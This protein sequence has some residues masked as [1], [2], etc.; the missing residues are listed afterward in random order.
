MRFEE[1]QRARGKSMCAVRFRIEL[2]IKRRKE[3]NENAFIYFCRQMHGLFITPNKHAKQ[4]E[5]N[6][7]IKAHTTT[8]TTT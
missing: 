2:L 1:N 8:T 4:I 7:E 6:S 3:K 5:D